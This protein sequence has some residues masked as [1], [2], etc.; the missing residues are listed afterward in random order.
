MIEI[1]YLWFIFY[2]YN[3]FVIYIVVGGSGY[4]LVSFLF[5][6]WFLYFD[7]WWKVSIGLIENILLI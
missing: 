1:I 4:R 3:I 2:W 7:F 5:C 6:F